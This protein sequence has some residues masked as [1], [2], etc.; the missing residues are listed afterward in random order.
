MKKFYIIA[1]CALFTVAFAGCHHH[2]H[3]HGHKD[4]KINYQRPTVQPKPLPPPQPSSH[5]HHQNHEAGIDD[6]ALYAFPDAFL[7][8]VMIRKGGK[9]RIKRA[10][11]LPDP[12]HAGDVGGEHVARFERVMKG[13]AL[14]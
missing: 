9:H 3:H 7:A 11:L 12:H 6:G 14:V 2:H 1:L 10:R 5:K 13:G 4:P 8:L